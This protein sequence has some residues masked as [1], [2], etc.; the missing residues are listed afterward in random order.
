MFSYFRLVFLLLSLPTITRV[1]NL[2]L[3][4]N[5]NAN[6][7]Q[8]YQTPN[9][10]NS[11]TAKTM[12]SQIL[13]N[14]LEKDSEFQSLRKFSKESHSVLVKYSWFVLGSIFNFLN[15]ACFYRMK[16]RNAQNIYLGALSLAELFNIQINIF[17]PMLHNTDSFS[18]FIKVKFA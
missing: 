1:N 12:P 15:F 16:K 14:Q 7:Q 6:N 17:I 8:N 18:R 5:K 2:I 3:R 10:T 9:A 13:H 11:S 4:T